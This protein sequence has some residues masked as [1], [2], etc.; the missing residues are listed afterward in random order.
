MLPS[1]YYRIYLPL[2]STLA[3]DTHL[4]IKGRYIT[5]ASQRMRMSGSSWSQLTDGPLHQGPH[6][7][8]TQR[9]PQKLGNGVWDES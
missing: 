5:A 1:S 7:T 2:N 4:Q 9:E 3:L 8:E 6:L